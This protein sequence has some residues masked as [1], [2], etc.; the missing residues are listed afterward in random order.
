MGREVRGGRGARGIITGGGS[1]AGPRAREGVT[2]K[3]TL[4]IN[5]VNTNMNKLM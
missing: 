4:I 1:V 2:I 3:H 5:I